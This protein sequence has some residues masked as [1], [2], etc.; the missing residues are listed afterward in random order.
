MSRRYPSLGLTHVKRGAVEAQLVEVRDLVFAQGVISE[1]S[2]VAGEIR[3]AFVVK[4]AL[5]YFVFR[6]NAMG[7]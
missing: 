5:V 6:Q 2:A 3:P 1:F 4:V 7:R